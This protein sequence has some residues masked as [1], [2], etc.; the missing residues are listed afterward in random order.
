MEGRLRSRSAPSASAARPLLARD[1]LTALAGLVFLLTTSAAWWALA[2]WPLAEAPEWIA[3]ARFVCFNAAPNGLPDAAGWLLLAGE[4]IGM[5]AALVAIAGDP[6]RRAV[7]A[8]A[9]RRVGRAAF[10]SGLAVALA[11]IAAA[12]LRIASAAR[13]SDAAAIFDAAR[14]PARELPR[15]DR[16]L[17][18]FELVDQEGRAL[19]KASL[20]GRPALVTF[21]FAHCTS[22]CPALVERSL[23]AQALLR[24][25]AR[26]GAL[27]VDRVPRVLIVT[28]DPWRDT[29]ARLPALAERWRLAPGESFVAS[30]EVDAVLRALDAFGVPR[31]RNDANGDLAH[32]P[33]VFVL[34]ATGRIAFASSGSSAELVDLLART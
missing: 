23:T 3:R 27:P 16:T 6:L 32:P 21:A 20:S 8:V 12:G 28:L 34:D 15:L 4:P 22:I 1:E 2:L 11:G 26:S 33:L 9:A 19:A 18:D 13:A 7:R 14:D 25:R 29:P 31:V 5:L 17:P 30:G 24:E 10:A